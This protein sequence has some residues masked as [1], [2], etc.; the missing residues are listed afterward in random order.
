MILT[1]SQQRRVVME[2]TFEEFSYRRGYSDGIDYTLYHTN[3]SLNED[4]FIANT[5]YQDGFNQ[6]LIDEVIFDE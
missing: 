4:E 5:D 2:L 6:A 3:D 1:A